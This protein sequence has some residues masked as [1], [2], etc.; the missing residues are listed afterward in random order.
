[1]QGRMQRGAIL[2]RGTGK[3]L[4]YRL[5]GPLEGCVPDLRQ[6]LGEDAR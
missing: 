2:E 1:M 3:L 4:E 5:L 6:I